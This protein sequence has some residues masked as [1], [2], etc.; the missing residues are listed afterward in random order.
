LGRLVGGM[1][2][3][4]K[5]LRGGLEVDLGGVVG[6]FWVLAGSL[7]DQC[8]L[9]FAMERQWRWQGESPVRLT[10]CMPSTGN[11]MRRSLYGSSIRYDPPKKDQ[12]HRALF[13][14]TDKLPNFS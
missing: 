7:A 6:E 13:Y 11:T 4:C 8:G 10:H 5:V 14:S 2:L 9:F 12:E 1:V 3:R